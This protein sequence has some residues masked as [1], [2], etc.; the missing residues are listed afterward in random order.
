MAHNDVLLLSRYFGGV[1]P[2]GSILLVH[3]SIA[4]IFFGW[5]SVLRQQNI[6]NVPTLYWYGVSGEFFWANTT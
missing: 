3:F 5:W 6:D 1:I 4:R 2:F